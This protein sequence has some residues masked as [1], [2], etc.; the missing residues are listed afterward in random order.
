MSPPRKLLLASLV[1][2]AVCLIAPTTKADTITFAPLVGPN[3][4]PYVGHVEA[5]YTVTP[6]QGNWLQ[7]QTYGN[8][9][10][11]IFALPVGGP[12]TS[13]IQ[14]ITAGP[15]TFSSVDFSSN[16]GISSFLIQG[17]LGGNNVFS[18]NGVLPQSGP[19]FTFTTIFSA[20]PASQIDMLSIQV[21]TGSGVTSINLDNIMVNRVPAAA[22]PEPTTLLL[23]GTGMAGIV[24]KV[25]WRK[26]SA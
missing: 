9:V 24:A 4:S 10:P 19:V 1:F 18:Q 22:V 2:A 16:N 12:T 15:F 26:K 25:R 23:L 5:G 6:T 20:F 13:A 14:V 21:V 7:G 11:S 17:F 8:P 3:G